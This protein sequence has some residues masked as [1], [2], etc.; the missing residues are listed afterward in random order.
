[1][2]ENS[3]TINRIINDLLIQQEFTHLDLNFSKLMLKM[4]D[5]PSYECGLGFCLATHWQG[6]GHV[7]VVL[8][9]LAG[10]LQPDPE[11]K[12]GDNHKFYPEMKQWRKLLLASGVVGEPGDYQPLILD[13]E[14]RLYLFRYYEYQHY[15]AT[16][17]RNRISKEEVVGQ[18]QLPKLLKKYFPRD[19]TYSSEQEQ[20]ARSSALY[21]FCLISGGPGTGKTTT[22]VKIMA[23]L[24]ELRPDANLKIAITAPTGKAAARL[25]EAI[26]MA[27]SLLNFS[28][29]TKELIPEQAFTI[30]R[31]LGTIQNSPYFRYNSENLLPYDV[32]IIDE[33][34]M[35][36]LALAAKL[37]SALSQKTKLILLGDRDQLA[38]V[39]AGSILADLCAGFGEKEPVNETER[40]KQIVYLTKSY[41]FGNESGIGHLA[42]AVNSGDSKKALELVTSNRYLDFL[43][44]ERPESVEKSSIFKERILSGYSEYITQ[45]DPDKAFNLFEKFKI[46]CA[47]RKGSSGVEGI[48]NLVEK[49]LSAKGLIPHD[50]TWY[51]GR[52]VII[53]KNDY[54]LSLYNGDLGI[55]LP[56]FE[57][58]GKLFIY[59]RDFDNKY[60]KIS[61]ERLPEHQTGYAIT[62]HKS[63]GSE[64][65]RVLLLL[66]SVY[67]QVVTRELIYT[68]ITRAKKIVEIW[69]NPFIFQTGIRAFA[70]RYS[71][72]KDLL[73]K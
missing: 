43:W 12:L 34:S 57:K 8:S 35:V 65:D 1:M 61:P 23:V 32:V 13:S 69:A 42:R 60:K 33:T 68:G 36:D 26:T 37:V 41:R 63:Q 3:I 44:Q 30:H 29:K 6:N 4:T 59:F 28:N 73:F 9:E 38:S 66:P 17:I 53:K 54:S 52:P 55:T 46:L 15:F 2:N 10:E 47:L 21:N 22:V 16:A 51:P 45:T 62:V 48:N 19:E 67:N 58:D 64:F 27:K 39:A 11:K 5:S 25:Q 49:F 7:C 24:L 71:G 56:D 70:K 20:A 14:N 18:E 50:T 72:L 40:Y 31:L